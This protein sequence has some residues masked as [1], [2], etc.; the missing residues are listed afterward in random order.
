MT[1]NAVLNAITDEFWQVVFD[2]YGTYCDAWHGV[3]EWRKNLTNLPEDIKNKN[4]ETLERIKEAVKTDPKLEDILKNFIDITPVIDSFSYCRYVPVSMKEKAKDW[5]LPQFSYADM[6][7]RNKMGGINHR[8]IGNMC[9]VTIYQY[10]DD[11]YRGK[12]AKVMGLEH[13][14]CIFADIFGDIAAIR[15]SIIHNGGKAVRRI[16]QNSSEV[17]FEKDDD[18]IIDRFKFENFVIDEIMHL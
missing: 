18:I 8:Y 11:H 16:P 13:K 4:A 10:W 14:N 12:L 17:W 3:L 9:A 2:T 15:K 1:E 7:D 5:I 6:L